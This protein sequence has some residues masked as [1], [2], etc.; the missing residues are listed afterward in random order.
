M[1]PA[2]PGVVRSRVGS[3]RS[4]PLPSRARRKLSPRPRSIGNDL[5]RE[6]AYAGEAMVPGER[7]RDDAPYG[8]N[9]AS[10]FPSPPRRAP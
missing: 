5:D 7:D 2:W 3:G 6:A 8:I 4:H 1:E 9:C 10:I